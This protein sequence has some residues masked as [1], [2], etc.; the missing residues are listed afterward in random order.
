[1]QSGISIKAECT[2]YRNN[3]HI[4]SKKKSKLSVITLDEKALILIITEKG[5]N[6]EFKFPL[7]KL[8]TIMKKFI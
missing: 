8:K 5:D 4:N 2:I 7:Q 6:R 3:M 1:M